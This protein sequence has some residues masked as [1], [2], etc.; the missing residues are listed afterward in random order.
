MFSKGPCIKV[1]VPS[2][3]L[4]TCGGNFKR[5]GLGGCFRSLGVC[6]QKELWGPISFLSLLFPGMRLRKARIGT[7]GMESKHTRIKSKLGRLASR[8][9]FPAVGVCCQEEL[10]ALSPESVGHMTF[11]SLLPPTGS[12]L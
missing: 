11:P 2:F 1:L 10:R 12:D 5:W 3:T 9:Y 4:V 8:S 7:G 6:L